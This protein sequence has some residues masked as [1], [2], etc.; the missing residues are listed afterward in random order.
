MLPSPT[1][2]QPLKGEP[3]P[4]QGGQTWVGVGTSKSGESVRTLATCV[5]TYNTLGLKT[6]KTIKLWG[7]I[8]KRS[9]GG[10]V[11]QDMSPQTGEATT[12]PPTQ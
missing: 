5:I 9:L 12:P 1:A 3:H 6:F 2:D 7:N 8:K 11:P 4:N 10:V